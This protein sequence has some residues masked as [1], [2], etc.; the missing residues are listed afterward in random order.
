[1][2][3]PRPLLIHSLNLASF[4]F[5][6]CFFVFLVPRF[7]AWSSARDPSQ[8]FILLETI[9]HEFDAIAKRRRV[10]KVEVIGDCYVAV[11]GLPD[12]RPDHAVTM[13]KFATDCINEMNRLCQELE[14]ELGPD[15]T[16]LGFRVG[17]NS[18]P[19][20]AG[21]L[22][23][24]KSR[25]Q[26]FGDTMNT[27]ARVSWDLTGLIMEDRVESYHCLFLSFFLYYQMESTGIPNRVQIS[28]STAEYLQ[29]VNK[30]HWFEPREDKVE[31]K[32]KGTLTTYLLK[33]QKDKR[34]GESS[35]GYVSE[36]DT[37]SVASSM[38][39]GANYDDHRGTD[40]RNRI[41]DWTVEVLADLLQEI[42]V[43]RRA[44]QVKSEPT[45]RLLQMEQSSTYSAEK[46]VLDD[47]KEIIELPEY[48]VS[49]AQRESKINPES[50][51]LGEDVLRELRTFVRTVASM[52]H[53]NRKYKTSG[54][55]DLL[56]R[57]GVFSSLCRPMMVLSCRV[58]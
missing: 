25:F 41:A 22:R 50:I 37:H 13:C 18:G 23:G 12:P 48:N 33:I 27:A 24:E 28:E 42:E 17:L 20:V 34:K 16:E 4:R 38:N 31:A 1:M 29:N 21:V 55:D 43:R 49:V 51:Q 47:V 54:L 15:T 10:F 44:A 14:V 52:Y 57:T 39:S 58:A 45:Y 32:G 19:V 56:C 6:S 3:R 26:L 7:T 5:V 11:C 53:D 9:Y 30:S 46:T 40:K 8:V 36:S 2:N 35:S